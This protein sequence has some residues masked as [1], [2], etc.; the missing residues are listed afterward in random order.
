MFIFLALPIFARNDTPSANDI[1]NE[2]GA[3]GLVATADISISILPHWGAA[4]P[5]IQDAGIIVKA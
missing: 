5:A 3:L 1:E 2:L 4:I